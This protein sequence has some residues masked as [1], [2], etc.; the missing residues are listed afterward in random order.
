MTTLFIVNCGAG[1]LLGFMFKV[2]VV[3]LLSGI[4]VLEA[5][6]LLV[7]GRDGVLLFFATALVSTHLCYGLGIGARAVFE[8]IMSQRRG[9][10]IGKSRATDRL[11]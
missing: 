8:R 1:L 6:L 2:H 3:F 4:I 5:A 9:G 10:V 7:A 11:D